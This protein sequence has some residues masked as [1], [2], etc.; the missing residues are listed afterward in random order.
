MNITTVGIYLEKDIV[1]VNEQN[2][3]GG[4]ENV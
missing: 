3:V 4:I 1:T 2:Q